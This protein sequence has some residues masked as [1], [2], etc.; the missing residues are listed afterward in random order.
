M[1][2]LTLML[3]TVWT[4]TGCTSGP[5]LTV[6][7][8]PTYPSAMLEKC[9]ETLSGPKGKSGPDLLENHTEV[10][11]AYHRCKDNHNALVNE[12]EENSK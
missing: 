5:V 6:E 3:L 8:R 11:Q 12:I 2:K 9:P 1:W 10:A 7:K 4:I